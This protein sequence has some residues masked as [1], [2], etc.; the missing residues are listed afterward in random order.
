M[1]SGD[2][3]KTPTRTLKK[4]FESDKI[5]LSPTKNCMTP[6]DSNRSSWSRSRICRSC[7]FAF[8]PQ[9]SGGTR[10]SP[11][12]CDQ[13]CSLGLRSGSDRLRCDPDRIYLK[14]NWTPIGLRSEFS[15]SDGVQKTDFELQRNSDRLRFGVRR[16]PTT[17]TRSP[18]VI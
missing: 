1:D 5:I 12:E 18:F 4:V 8:I 6:T 17:P 3:L 11:S 2:I 13:S 16:S 10:R 7:N 14:Q 9:D 15:E